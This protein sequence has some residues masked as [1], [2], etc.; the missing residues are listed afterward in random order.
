MVDKEG[1]IKEI[2][3]E[4]AP[5]AIGPYSQAVE[6]GGFV[7]VSGQIP[8]DPASGELENG[9]IKKQALLVIENAENILKECGLSLKDVVRSELFLRDINDYSSV[10][11]VY[12][13]KFTHNVKPARSVVEVS[14]LPKNVGIELSCI[15]YSEGGSS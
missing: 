7:F 14:N 12:S 9:D 10:N 2:I 11:E 13:S 4:D 3:C 5:K 15:A 6:A 8:I 1:K